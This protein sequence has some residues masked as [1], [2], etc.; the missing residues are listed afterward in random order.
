MKKTCKEC[1]Y[2]NRNKKCFGFKIACQKLGVM[3]NAKKDRRSCKHYV[4]EP[5]TGKCEVS[6]SDMIRG[7][8]G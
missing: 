7:F 5:P 2:G 3:V 4:T 6:Y 1:W 8:Y